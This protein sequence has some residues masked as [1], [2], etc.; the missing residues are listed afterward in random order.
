MMSRVSG[1][2]DDS[3]SPLPGSSTVAFKK[4]PQSSGFWIWLPHKAIVSLEF[5]LPFP[6]KSKQAF[7]LAPRNEGGESGTAAQSVRESSPRALACA[8]CA[9]RRVSAE[10]C[11]SALSAPTSYHGTDGE[12]SIRT[13]IP[14]RVR[15]HTHPPTRAGFLM[16]LAHAA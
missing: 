10:S 5:Y 2:H 15:A 16:L 13:R 4:E 3:R 9:E 1:H 14:Q 7:H 6:L 12:D 8:A 11:S